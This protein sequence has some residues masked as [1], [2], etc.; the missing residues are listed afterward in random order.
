MTSFALD[1]HLN[2]SV[3]L[4]W[5]LRTAGHEVRMASH[6]AATDSITRAGLTAI[7]V[8]SDHHLDAVVRQAGPGMYTTHQRPDFLNNRPE[9]L[10][11]EFLR[12]SDTIIT[13][14]FCAQLNNDSMVDELVQFARGWHPDLVIWEPFTFAGAVAARASGAAH[15]RLLSFPD[16]FLSVRQEFLR[17]MGGTWPELYDDTLSEWLTWT[18][19]RFGCDFDEEIVTGQWTIDQ[20]PP[21][22][23]LAL[24]QRMIPMRYVPYNGPGPAVVPDWLYGKPERPRVCLTLGE[25]IRQ[26]EFPNAVAVDD[27]FEA[28]G[29]LD[30]ELVATLNAEERAMVSRVPDN[31]RM[32]EHVPLHALM[33][34]CSAI[35]H[36]GGAGTWATAAVYGVPQIAMGWMWDAVYRARR[37]EELGAGLHIPSFELTPEDLRGKL[38]Q[39][40]EE[41]SFTQNAQLL[42][43][44]MR[45]SP[46][47]NEVVAVLEDAV[48]R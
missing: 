24:G 10:D 8:G 7:P 33:P 44:Q 23:G 48:A 13:S 30:V 41:P 47:P 40:L 39:L 12:A 25:T 3:P 22:V 18:L 34:S 45:Q 21:S 35:V 4:A 28:I 5:A 36:H 11:L 29:D 20:L 32:V 27:V 1:A 31:V 14:M 43:E 15:A 2:G 37:L 26:T 17:K 38:A 6:P 42:H 16:T 46:T 9:R 19:E